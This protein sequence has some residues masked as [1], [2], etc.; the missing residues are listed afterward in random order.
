M[1]DTE[2]LWLRL[3]NPVG[4]EL[5]VLREYLSSAETLNNDHVYNILSSIPD[6]RVGNGLRPFMGATTESLRC[7]IA[8]ILVH[9]PSDVTD[10]IH[11]KL[12]ILKEKFPLPDPDKA[13]EL[14]E[15]VIVITLLLFFEAHKKN[16]EEGINPNLKYYIE[17]LDSIENLISQFTSATIHDKCAKLRKFMFRAEPDVF[18]FVHQ[19]FDSFVLSEEGYSIDFLFVAL[20]ARNPMDISSLLK[21]R[22]TLFENLNVPIITEKD[23]A[24]R[25]NDFFIP[26]AAAILLDNPLL[27]DCAARNNSFLRVY[28]QSSYERELEIDKKPASEIKLRHRPNYFCVNLNLTPREY[29]LLLSFEVAAA[30]AIHDKVYSLET[31]AEGRC[32]METLLKVAKSSSDQKFQKDMSKV[33]GFGGD[34]LGSRKANPGPNFTTLLNF[35]EPLLP[36]S[37]PDYRVGR[38]CIPFITNNAIHVR[39]LI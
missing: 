33:L 21:H 8:S 32:E 3:I 13:G 16:T 27:I 38:S 17:N 31:F 2:P 19:N 37:S 12:N 39:T 11:S 25:S 5:E 36:I 10:F 34:N 1:S 15:F 22:N 7:R 14:P 20:Q 4:N 28:I 18:K 35:R 9:M 24:Q 6:I 30:I 26:Q 23:S 29:N